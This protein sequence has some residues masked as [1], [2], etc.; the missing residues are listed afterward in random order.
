M[1]NPPDGYPREWRQGMGAFGRNYG[2][3]LA[4]RTSQQTAR[5]LTAAALHEDFRYHPSASKNPWV[6]GF[7]AIG[8]TFVD[9]SDSGSNRIAFANFAGAAA[10]GFTP[11]LYLPE[12]Y[13]TL[14]RAETRMAFTFGEYAVRNLTR[15]FAPELFKVARKLHLPATRFPIPEWWKRN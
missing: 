10:A 4:T 9:K 8:Y 5:F 3:A 11:N 2:A 12:R 7:H 1:L 13:N 15:E 6:R 14:S